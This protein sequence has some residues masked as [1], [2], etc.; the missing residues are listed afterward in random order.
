[1]AKCRD[2][3]GILLGRLKAVGTIFAFS[4]SASDLLAQK[5]HQFQDDGQKQLW[6]HPGL[7]V[8]G[9]LPNLASK[10]EGGR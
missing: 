8:K 7:P 5:I 4:L 1:V 6:L 10:M 2:S 9:L 3:I